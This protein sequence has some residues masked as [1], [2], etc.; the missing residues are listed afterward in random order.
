MGRRKPYSKV[1]KKNEIRAEHVRGMGDVVWRQ[2][3]C[4]NP[5]CTEIIT[6]PDDSI[7]D[8]FEITCPKCGYKLIDGDSTKFYDY[9]MDVKDPETGEVNTVSEGEFIISHREY[10]ESAQ[11]V[12][13]CL[14]CNTI[15]PLDYFDKHSARKSG[16]QGECRMCKQ[17]YNSIKNGTRLTDQHRESAQRR[18]LLLDVAGNSKI[19]SAKVE[20]RF[21][22]R[23]FNCN[24]DLSGVTDAR[25]KPLDHTLPVYYLYPI[26]TENATLLCRDC[27]GSKSGA[28]PSD[29]YP[30]QKLRKLSLVTGI[31]YSLLKGEPKYNQVALDWLSEKG[32]V[33][34]LIVKYSAYMPEVIALR[35]RILKATEIDFFSYS[36]KISKVWIDKAN[37]L[38]KKTND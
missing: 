15:K 2:F 22:H 10:L 18:R 7:V 9:T 34:G 23:C 25:E 6:V 4:L 3:Q 36:E 30:D 11:K 1:N 33:D 37:E 35:N 32:N 12:K 17:I 21:E 26:S 27:N 5:E 28:W 14:V 13:Y 20:E 38:L 8:D 16:R 24:K 31:E 29:F 19:D